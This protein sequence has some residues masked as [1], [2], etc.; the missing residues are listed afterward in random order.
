MGTQSTARE[1]IA[2]GAL[3]TSLGVTSLAGAFIVPNRDDEGPLPSGGPDFQYAESPI[4]TG[5]YEGGTTAPVDFNV[6]WSWPMVMQYPT[7]SQGE[8]NRLRQLLKCGAP[9]ASTTEITGVTATSGISMGGVFGIQLSGGSGNV[10][11]GVEVGDVVRVRDASDNLVSFGEVYFVDAVGHVL[12]LLSTLDIPNGSTYKIMRGRRFK[13]ATTLEFAPMEY[14]G[15]DA[16]VFER[17]LDTHPEQWSW[18]FR[19]GQLGIRGAWS[20]KA[21]AYAQNTSAYS[22][23][24]VTENVGPIIAPKTDNIVLRY[25][26]TGLSVMDM[27]ATIRCPLGATKYA[28]QLGAASL[29]PGRITSSGSFTSFLDDTTKLAIVQAGSAASLLFAATDTSKQSIAFR[30]PSVKLTSA[31]KQRE[32]TFISQQIGWQSQRNTATDSVGVRAFTW[33]T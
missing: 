6:D 18:G 29:V 11:T 25:G 7:P 5:D 22:S 16:N 32:S 13:P 23:G 14:A 1:R 19:N 24:L 26:S 8:E 28:T 27:T 9:T 2:S 20:G 4:A 33:P 17:F 31:I 21:T 3:S 10:E 15:L 12:G 30:W